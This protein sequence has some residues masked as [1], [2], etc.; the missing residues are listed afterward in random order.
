MQSFVLNL[1][2]G[3]NEE[4]ADKPFSDGLTET[5]NHVIEQVGT[6]VEAAATEGL[7][8]EWKVVTT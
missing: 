8:I 5:C 4:P 7:E 1:D 3:H 2:I 6:L